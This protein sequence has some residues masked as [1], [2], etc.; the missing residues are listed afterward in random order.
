MWRRLAL[1]DSDV[2]EFQLQNGLKVLL[3][4]VRS[5]PVVSNWIWYRVG[6]RNELPG[7]TGISHWVEHMMFKGTPTFP[8]GSIMRLV[9]KNGGTLN[10]FTSY[11]YTAYFETL[12]AERWDLGLRIEADRMANSVFDPNEV[13]SERTVIISEREGSE[14]SPNFLLREELM[15]LAFRAH[16]YG[17]QVIGWKEDL[18]QLT[19]ADLWSHYKTYYGPHNAVLIVVGDMDLGAART[20][21]EE[22][23]APILAGSPPPPVAVVEPGQTGERRVVV[24]QPG[25]AQY[26]QAAFHIPVGRHPDNFPLMVLDAVLSGAS[27]MTFGGGSTPTHRSARLYKA[28]VETELATRAGC[29]Y[30]PSID[31]GL[32]HFQATERE[33][34][35]LEEVEQAMWAEVRRIQ[36]EPASQ[37]ELVKAQKQARA[38][39]AYAL[40]G[41]TNQALWLGLMEMVDSYARFHTFLDDLAAV[42]AADVQRVAQTYLVETQRSVGWFV[43][44][45]LAPSQGPTAKGSTEIG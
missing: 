8:K 25:T 40:E 27:P 41:V 36:D 29:G 39:F 30:T 13:D 11:D 21:I 14:N 32:F 44:T 24:R 1:I 17:H 31:P 18:R 26:F 35:S 22:L 4:P 42:T 33:G 15:S 34:H 20:R 5:A 6:S 37:E 23:F 45:E 2:V 7:K 38:Q 12:P 43:P 10:G 28:L 9:N 16:P 3:K 19:H